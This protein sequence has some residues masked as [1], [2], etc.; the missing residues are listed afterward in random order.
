MPVPRA[1]L[2]ALAVTGLAG[3]SSPEA[4][5]EPPPKYAL[6]G[7]ACDAVAPAEFEPLTGTRP[8][9]TPSTLKQGLEGGNCVM[10]FDGSGGYLKLTTFIAIHPSG[11]PAAKTMFDDFKKSDT[12][13]SGPG[14]DITVSDISGLGSAAYLYRKYDDARAWKPDEVWLYKFGVHHGALV[15]TIIGT[16]YA[17]ESAGW[18][19]TEQDLQAKIRKTAEDTMK[20]L[21]G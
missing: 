4:A 16:G 8:A 6:T 7:D 3:C 15:L 11:E 18:P 12:G 19:A 10:E 17:R 9:K 21:S 20:T 2:A 5:P 1:L 14:T 13:R